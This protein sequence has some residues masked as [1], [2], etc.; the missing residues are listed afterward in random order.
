[1]PFALWNDLNK[2]VVFFIFLLGF[3]LI[4]QFLIDALI[5]ITI[6]FSL[7]DCVVRLD[8]VT[9]P[10]LPVL[11][12]IDTE[13]IWKVNSRHTLKLACTFFLFCYQFQIII[14]NSKPISYIAFFLSVAFFSLSCIYYSI[15][16]HDDFFFE[17]TEK[18]LAMMWHSICWFLWYSICDNKTT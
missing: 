10:T 15:L 12:G 7:F 9:G 3:I 17:I 13:W 5:Q 4:F 1:M 2:F 8:D 18:L 16:Q 14:I 6:N 11:S